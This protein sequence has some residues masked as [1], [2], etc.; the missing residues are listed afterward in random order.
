MSDEQ[1]SHRMRD[2]YCTIQQIY[3]EDLFASSLTM[4]LY[5]DLN[6]RSAR[7]NLGTHAAKLLAP[8]YDAAEAKT[9]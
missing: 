6:T 7:R 2:T 1:V 8:Q 5:S 3:V 9:Y 4:Y